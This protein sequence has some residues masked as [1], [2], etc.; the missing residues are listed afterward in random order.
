MKKHIFKDPV[1]MPGSSLSPE[2]VYAGAEPVSGTPG[3]AYLLRRG[4]GAD[5]ATTFGVRYHGDF[6]GRP[7]V[8]VPLH[9]VQG[10]LTSLHGRYLSTAR[11][12]DKMFTVGRPGGVISLP[13]SWR[14]DPLI[15]V[16]GLFDALSLA[17]SGWSSV[18]TIGRHVPWLAEVSRGRTV[19]AAFDAGR[20]G[21][22]NAESYRKQLLGAEV[23]RLP[24]PPRCKDWN[25]ALVKRGREAVSK[26]VASQ[27]AAGEAMG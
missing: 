1:S 3:H 19:W 4:I 8:I 18:A 16:E 25:T 23:R 20:P 5:I 10:N 14:V 9:D 21:E 15:V 7:A 11:L 17:V 12:Q 27:M 24:P 22:A 26:W 13:E 6:A 2:E